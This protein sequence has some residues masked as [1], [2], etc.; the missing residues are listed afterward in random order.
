MA[1]FAG[2][3]MIALAVPV[4]A[5][6][7]E[8]RTGG[9]H[10]L[11]PGG[12][13]LNLI[14]VDQVVAA[15]RGNAPGVGFEVIDKLNVTKS[16]NR[17]QLRGLDHPGKIRRFRAPVDHRPGDAEAGGLRFGFFLCCQLI[18]KFR[19]DLI[20]TAVLAAGEYGFDDLFQFSGLN[21][22]KRQ[23]R[24]GSTY[25]PGK[26]HFSKFLQPRPSLVSSSSAS[27]GPQLPEA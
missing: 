2:K 20:Q 10:G 27:F 12:L 4:K 1:A 23:T 17:C 5:G 26:N 3:H 25:V 14:K 15:Q 21:F 11:I 6:F 9:D 24:V 8:A 18:G 19:N 7:P 13:S 22:V 16:K